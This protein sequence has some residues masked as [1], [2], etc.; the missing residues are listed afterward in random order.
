M[1]LGEAARVGAF[2]FKSEKLN[3]LTGFVGEMMK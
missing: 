2:D 3:S 1:N